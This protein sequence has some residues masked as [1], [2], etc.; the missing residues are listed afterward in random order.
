MI[1]MLFQCR[2][3]VLL[4]MSFQT[5]PT[6]CSQESNDDGLDNS[7]QLKDLKHHNEESTVFIGEED[8]L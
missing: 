1:T 2:I 5:K 7:V 3:T 4:T 6:Y 8:H